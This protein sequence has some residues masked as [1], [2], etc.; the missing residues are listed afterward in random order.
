MH[1]LKSCLLKLS[2]RPLGARAAKGGGLV[3]TIVEFVGH[4]GDEKTIFLVGEYPEDIFIQA[5]VCLH[6][7]A[8]S[9][10]LFVIGI[11]C[12]LQV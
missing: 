4:Q 8:L 12:G 5:G 10:R 2:A 9:S 1:W 11:V 6:S 3:Y 7:C